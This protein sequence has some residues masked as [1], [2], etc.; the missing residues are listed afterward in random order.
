MTRDERRK[1]IAN[2]VASA[3]SNALAPT[4]AKV[5]LAAMAE[6]LRELDARVVAVEK[7]NQEKSNAEKTR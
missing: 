6:E 7:S 1:A 5:G 2:A 3:T 4:W